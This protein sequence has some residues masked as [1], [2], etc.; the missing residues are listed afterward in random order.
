MNKFFSTVWC[1]VKQCFVVTDEFGSARGKRASL[2]VTV[3][4]LVF[5][6]STF[7]QA[8]VIYPFVENQVAQAVQEITGHQTINQ[9]CA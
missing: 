5:S 8:D 4:T 3:G 7:A 6:A 2:S 1:E 9:V